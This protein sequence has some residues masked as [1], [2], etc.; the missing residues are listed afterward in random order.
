M[1]AREAIDDSILRDYCPR[2]DDAT[3]ADHMTLLVECDDHTRDGEWEDYWGE[4]EGEEWRV[5]AK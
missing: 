3:E 4:D 5:V 2:L 1:T